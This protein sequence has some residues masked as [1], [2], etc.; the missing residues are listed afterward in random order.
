MVA[1][2]GVQA[3]RHHWLSVGLALLSCAQA[4]QGATGLPP[5]PRALADPGTVRY[6]LE[7]VINGR[8]SGQVVAVNARD[9]RYLLDAALLR[10]AGV[11][12][13]DNP[14]GTI[15]LDDLTDVQV[16]YDSASQQL[17]LQVPTDWL[18]RQRIEDPGLLAHIPASSSLG[19]LFNYDLYYSAPA[20]NATPYLS[21]LLEQRA[22][23]GFATLS[24]TGVYNHYFGG[25]DNPGN[26]YLRYDTYWRYNDEQ[27][28]RSYQLGDYINGALNWTNPV[29]MGGLRFSRNFEVRP[30]LVTYPLLRYDGQAAVPSTVDLFINGYKASSSDLQPGP[31]AIS[32]VPY[33]SG[34]GEATIVTTD[35][36]GRQ[37]STS[38]PFYVSNTLLARGLSDFDLSLGRLREDYGRRSLA[39]G[40]TAASGIYRYG[41]NDQL[42]LAGHAEAAGELQLLG[43]GSD[44]A[45]ATFGT[46]SLATSASASAGQGDS[47]QQYLLGYSYY[48]RRI[49]VN[50]QHIQRSDGYHDLSSLGG[51][52]LSRRADQVSASLSLD[53]QGSI[54]TGYFDIQARDGNRTRLLNLSYSRSLGNRSSVYLTLNKDLADSG[55]S[56]LL[57]WVLPFEVHG[58]LNVGMTRD[59]QGRY[60]ERVV[61]SRA[62][63]SEGGF[64]WNL[65]QGGGASRYQQADLTW[66]TQNVQLRAG[67][68]GQAGNH[69]RWADAS[70]SLVWMDR[71]LFASNRI[72]DAFVL[73]STGGYA[74]VPIRYENQRVGQSDENGHLLVPWVA[75]YHPAK[76]QVDSLGLPA[77]V[78]VPDVEQRVS[79]RQGSG[80]L[81][82][83]PM[84]TVVAASISLVDEQGSPLPLGSRAEHLASGQ[85]AIVGWDGQ[86]YFEDLQADNQ[87]RVRLGDGGLCQASFRLD[88]HKP[89]VSQIGPLPCRAVSGDNP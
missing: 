5:A 1:P 26:R 36:Q 46:L 4:A 39:Y 31:F 60:S 30:D 16:D 77:N 34:A 61:W 23:D 75:A 18:P 12:L 87:L 63:P 48:S 15:V 42:T 47:G 53:G 19:A 78:R 35:A 89:S 81:L 24:N 54:G 67:L 74:Q 7:L 10:E 22:F 43:V 37:V 70:G 82:D 72:N 85:Q 58:L 25:A 50:L 45:L 11:R 9:G 76:F 6:Y 28:L 64:G 86:V 88:I 73:V 66:R 14:V 56:V 40:D 13:P 71:A 8:N 41:L 52:R 80:A 17:R 57:Q 83:F 33:I 84:R 44:I 20:N 79:V 38:L 3:C 68:Y 69:T 55:Y 21:A 32:N 62:A 65:G 59:S 29:R 2:V 49:G 51:Y 27:A